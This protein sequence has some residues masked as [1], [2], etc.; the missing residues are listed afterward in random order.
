VPPENKK[1]NYPE[2]ISKEEINELP[3]RSFPGKIRLIQTKEALDRALGALRR[4]TILGFDTET[5]PTFTK[6]VTHLPSLLQ[7]ATGKS[8]FL[9][10]LNH[11]DNL[12]KLTPIL[13]NPNC[14]KVGVAVKD[15]IIGLQKLENFQPKGFVDIGQLA[16]KLGMLTT[17]LRSLTAIFLK[18]RITKKAQVSNWA[19]KEL[20]ESQIQ[21]AATDAWVS[22]KIFLKMR[23]FS[24]L[25]NEL[26]NTL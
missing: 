12:K 1:Q 3:V 5:K 14:F 9:I 21:Y 23:R 7:L 26:E 17:G 20:S 18:F 13:S 15:D 24:I 4:E 2:R 25:A 19:R 8:V 16:R 6:G 22:R 10:R 11:F